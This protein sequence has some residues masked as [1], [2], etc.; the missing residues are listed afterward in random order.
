M[1]DAVPFE[2]VE[3]RAFGERVWIAVTARGVRAVGAPGEGREAFLERVAPA[4]RLGE[5]E[6]RCSGALAARA[7]AGF[8]ARAV[9]GRWSSAVPLDLEGSELARAVWAAVA[10]VPSGARITY[11]ALAA[12]VGRPRAV[13]AVGA[14]NRATPAPPFVPHHRVV[15]GRG[16]L[17]APDSDPWSAWRRRWFERERLPLEPARRAPSS[18]RRSTPSGRAPSRS[19]KARRTQAPSGDEGNP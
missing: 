11:A 13:R 6:P 5:L 4:A 3:A 16:E 2:L 7:A 12:K 9:H 18:R 14:L 1:V 15:N 17:V 10:S 19:S 8:V